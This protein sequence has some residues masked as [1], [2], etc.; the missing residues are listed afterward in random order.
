[1]KSS[2]SSILLF[3]AVHGF[4]EDL[5]HG[6]SIKRRRHRENNFGAAITRR[7]FY[8]DSLGQ[9]KMNCVVPGNSDLGVGMCIDLQ[10]IESSANKEDP[11]QEKKISGKYFITEVNHQILMRYS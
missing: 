1:M 8:G 11:E 4:R 9:V 2:L 3:E 10:M 7:K 6:F 5:C